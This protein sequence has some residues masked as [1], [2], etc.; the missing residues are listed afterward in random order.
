MTLNFPPIA[1]R[2]P[3]PPAIFDLD[4][5]PSHPPA[6]EMPTL[7]SIAVEKH[8]PPSPPPPPQQQDAS[9]LSDA[10]NLATTNPLNFVLHNIAASSHH[11]TQRPH[12]EGG[13]KQRQYGVKY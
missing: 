3:T 7:Q 5:R 12:N 11:H 6:D 1:P 9:H 13:G 10:T 8:S 4:S 2:L